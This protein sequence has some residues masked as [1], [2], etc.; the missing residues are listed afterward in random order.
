M[1]ATHAALGRLRQELSDKTIAY[2]CGTFDL[3]HIGHIEFLEWCAQQADLLVIGLHSDDMVHAKKGPSR[4][5]IPE[6]HRLRMVD[7]L[8]VVDYAFIVESS[9]PTV[10]PWMTVVRELRPDVCILGPDWADLEMTLWK[11][12]I[13][14]AKIRVSP[15]RKGHSTTAIVEN[16]ISK[17]TGS[18]I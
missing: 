10:L 8:R 6:S 1:I 16:I 18:L 12:M 11:Q 2:T 4:P 3:L 14:E 9:D 13:P 15:D 5:I 17:A 7:A